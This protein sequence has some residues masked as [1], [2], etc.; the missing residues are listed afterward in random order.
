VLIV[1]RCRY[2]SDLEV[3]VMGDVT[4][5]AC[6]VDDFTAREAGFKGLFG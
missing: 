2:V 3:L 6:C 5:G 1:G 4:S